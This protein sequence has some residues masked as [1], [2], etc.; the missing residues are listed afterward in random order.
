MP[1]FDWLNGNVRHPQ[2]LC[3]SKLA[4]NLG[5]ASIAREFYKKPAHFSPFGNPHKPGRQK[6]LY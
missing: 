4:L 3:R 2:L 6:N 5:P 1:T